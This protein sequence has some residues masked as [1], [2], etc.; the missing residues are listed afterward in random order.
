MDLWHYIDISLDKRPIISYNSSYRDKD[1]PEDLLTGQEW[2]KMGWSESAGISYCQ[3]HQSN[4]LRPQDR[5]KK[6][7]R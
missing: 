5:I 1:L 7:A 6:E 3:S 2:S 4:S